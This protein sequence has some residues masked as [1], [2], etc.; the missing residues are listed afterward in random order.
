MSQDS[1]KLDLTGLPNFLKPKLRLFL[2]VDIAGSTAA[3][4][5]ASNFFKHHT[6]EANSL[7][8]SAEAP[9]F[10]Q[11]YHNASR[12]LKTS[13]IFYE[14]FGKEFINSWN[15]A[16]LE[17][18]GMPGYTLAAMDGS[19]PAFWKAAGDEVL[20]YKDITDWMQVVLTVGAWVVAMKRVRPQLRVAYGGSATAIDLKG[21]AW[22]AG[23]PVINTALCVDPTPS[24]GSTPFDMQIDAEFAKIPVCKNMLYSAF[25]FKEPTV[26]DI[27][28]FHA[29]TIKPS[30][31]R[32]DFI[33]PLID[34]GFRISQFAEIERMAISME[35]VHAFIR[36][37]KQH[38]G[39]YNPLDG[40]IHAFSGNSSLSSF[41]PVT[42]GYSGRQPLKGISGTRGYPM[43][44]LDV[45]L[46]DK[47]FAAESELLGSKNPLTLD[48]KELEIF[49]NQYFDDHSVFSRP[50]LVKDDGTIILDK[51]E[52]N[53]EIK[54]CI[55]SMLDA[56]QHRLNML[57]LLWKQA[58]ATLN[59][60]D[61]KIRRK[62]EMQKNETSSSSKAVD[63]SELKKLENNLEEVK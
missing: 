40:V 49:C 30:N 13:V 23:F 50:Y 38:A 45:N 34:L 12:W 22:L 6:Q 60:I 8:A 9:Q 39:F 55:Q 19:P 53:E 35:V 7:S 48:R 56:H 57:K 41:P 5:N 20:F 51:S 28:D 33:G 63:E 46:E 27:F 37:N 4:Q 32:I 14:T 3:K 42:L 29:S 31:D 36:A 44:Y 54:Q 43:F 59:K 1:P 21:S 47:I 18:K 24:T 61:V 26:K 2:S 10:E 16:V 52:S 15:A 62:D 17:S 11:E 25:L 58:I